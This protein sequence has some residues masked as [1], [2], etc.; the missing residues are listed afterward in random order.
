MIFTILFYIL[1]NATATPTQLYNTKIITEAIRTLST[2]RY[3]YLRFAVWTCDCSMLDKHVL[4]DT[5]AVVNNWV[6]LDQIPPP[7]PDLTDKYG[8][9]LGADH[10]HGNKNP[11]L[12]GN[13]SKGSA[14]VLL[15]WCFISSWIKVLL[16]WKVLNLRMSEDL[17]NSCMVWRDK[18][19]LVNNITAWMNT[20]FNNTKVTVYCRT[21]W[22]GLTK[23]KD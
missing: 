17:W 8:P 21:V 7:P 23:D 4:G 22:E 6:K 20:K 12:F 2:D 3:I 14:F 11:F 15:L 13:L 19:S 9:A 5:T 1:T 16:F 10:R 18:T